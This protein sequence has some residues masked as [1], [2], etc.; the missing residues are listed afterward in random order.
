MAPTRPTRSRSP[1][2]VRPY[3]FVIGTGGG[4]VNTLTDLINAI[5]GTA[6][7]NTAITASNVGGALSITADDY[8]SSFTVGGDADAVAGLG[9]TANTYAPGTSTTDTWNLFYLTDSIATGTQTAWQNIGVDYVF[10]SNGQL[11]PPVTTAT[12]TGL[13]VNGINLGN[14]TLD[15]GANGITQFADSNG[16]AKVTDINQDGFAAGELIGITVS[17]EAALWRATPTGERLILPRLRWPASTVTAGWRKP[18]A[19]R[20]APHPIPVRR[21]SDR[22]VPLSVRPWRGPTP[23]SP[24]NLPS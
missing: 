22:W 7:L 1:L 17:E 24:M 10:G 20:F 15:H 8:T 19:V 12:I 21:S 5:N 23:T 6:G 14:I 4:E 3:N 2:A 11:A 9:L 18:M 16:V 13:T